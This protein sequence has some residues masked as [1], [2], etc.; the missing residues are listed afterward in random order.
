[1]RKMGERFSTFLL[2]GIFSVFI[3]GS[4]LKAETSS[5]AVIYRFGENL[6]GAEAVSIS[7]EGEILGKWREDGFLFKGLGDQA[8]IKVETK[9]VEGISREIISFNPIE[10]T[11]RRLR[12]SEVPGGSRLSINYFTQRDP[13]LK[14]VTY[15]YLSVWVGRHLIRKL[16]VIVSEDGWKQAHISLGILPFL[17]SNTVFTFELS[18]QGVHNLQFSFS[19]ELEA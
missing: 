11:T 13:E 17:N 9:E 6:L 10:K 15:L 8:G 3:G 4:S 1:M 2:F 18:G 7:N 5:N 19:A 16:P 14:Q 12:F